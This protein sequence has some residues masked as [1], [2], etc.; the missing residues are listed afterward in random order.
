[1]DSS[2]NADGGERDEGEADRRRQHQDEVLV[3]ALAEGLGYAAAG[4]LA[5]V[6]A[7]TVRRRMA[8]G[9]FAALVSARRGQRV[10]EVTGVLVGLARRVVATLDACMDSERPVDRIRAA[11]GVLVELHR[12]RDQHD[13]EERLRLLE[14]AASQPARTEWDDE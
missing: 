13:L 8:D 4:D 12:F 6:S 5:R 7:R 9:G 11:Q 2:T 3:E 14:Q 1:M 10:G